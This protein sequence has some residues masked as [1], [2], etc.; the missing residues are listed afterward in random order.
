MIK[1]NREIK[2]FLDNKNERAINR[3]IFRTIS[4]AIASNCE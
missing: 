1:I 4:Q 3:R 2:I